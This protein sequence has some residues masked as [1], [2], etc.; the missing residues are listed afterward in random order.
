MRPEVRNAL[1]YYTNFLIEQSISD[2]KGIEVKDICV[3]GS[4]ANY[5]YSSKSD[6]DMWIIARNKSC[7]YL[8]KDEH[9]F[10]P[11]LSS[12]LYSVF[13][14]RY[15]F[16]YKGRFLDIKMAPKQL[17]TVFGSYSLLHDKWNAFPDRHL[18]DHVSLSELCDAYQKR[19]EK[20]L[21][22][23]KRITETYK[24]VEQ[25]EKLND[26]YIDI[27]QTISKIADLDEYN[28]EDVAKYSIYEHDDCSIEDYLIY[29]LL[30]Y[31]NVL[32]PLGSKVIFTYNKALSLD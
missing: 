20:V 24:G 27:I 8:S 26:F 29:K 19:K 2:I 6:I 23:I 22:H 17:K 10:G 18:T 32:R 25:A 1:L 7:S 21:G 12:Q 15:K 13:N 4:A 28:K 3:L 30:N 16:F 31:D 14:K 11:F 5:F 9:Y